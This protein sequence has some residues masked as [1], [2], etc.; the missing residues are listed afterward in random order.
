MGIN[1]RKNNKNY[2]K[3]KLYNQIYNKIQ[4]KIGKISSLQIFNSII[5]A[6]PTILLNIL[7]NNYVNLAVN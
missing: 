7:Q 4:Q 2:S 6:K 5:I 1:L 3:N